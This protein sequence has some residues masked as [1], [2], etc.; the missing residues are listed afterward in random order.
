MQ[1]YPS[2][3]PPPLWISETDEHGNPVSREVIEAAHRI[4]SRV[5]QYVRAAGQDLAPAAE[6]LEAACHCVSRA[7]RRSRQRNHIR[8]LDSYLYL[9]FVRKYNR[10]MV[11]E[12]RIQYVDSVETFVDGRIEPDHSWVSML[13]DEIQFK[14]ILSYLDPKIQVMVIRRLRRDSWAEIGQ[15]FGIS[16]HN[17]EVQFA[18]AIKK[19]R[20][21]LLGKGSERR[22]RGER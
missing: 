17:A 8:S 7:I 4:W 5:L 16:A 2:V 20:S 14:Q 21:R 10:R 19:A 11:R 12:E 9:A 13:E 18:N 15:A 22:G 6:I 1:E 3:S